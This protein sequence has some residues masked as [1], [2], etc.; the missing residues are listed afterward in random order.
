MIVQGPSGTVCNCRARHCALMAAT[1]PPCLRLPLQTIAH[2]VHPVPLRTVLCH[3]TGVLLGQS[4]E[5]LC[6]VLARVP[7]L[8]GDEKPMHMGNLCDA[9]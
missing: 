4:M 1:Q 8:W 6:N 2:V 9:E 5:M 3:P 7:F